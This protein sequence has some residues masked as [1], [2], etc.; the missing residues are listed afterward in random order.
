[1]T[2]FHSKI[3]VSH[4]EWDMYDPF[5]E[6]LNYTLGHLSDVEVD[7]LPKFKSYIVFVLCNKGVSS[8]CDL[9]G[10]SFKPDIALMSIQDAHKLYGLNQVDMLDVF[11]FIG[12]IAED[13]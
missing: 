13:C 4:Y 2:T 6:A 10:S 1:M 7:G 12:K 5:T 11:Q 9:A 8:N 3:S